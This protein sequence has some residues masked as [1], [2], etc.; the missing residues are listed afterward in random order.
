SSMA[1]CAPFSSN[2]CTVARPI[3]PFAPV[4]ATT[5]PAISSHVSFIVHPSLLHAYSNLFHM[6]WR[7]MH[8]RVVHW[9]SIAL[10]PCPRALCSSSPL[11]LCSSVPLFLSSPSRFVTIGSCGAMARWFHLSLWCRCRLARH[12]AKHYQ[13]DRRQCAPS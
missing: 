8:R 1:T 6:Y 12:R 3:P 13:Q 9:R 5:R 2:A 10:T 11:F 4:T 7:V